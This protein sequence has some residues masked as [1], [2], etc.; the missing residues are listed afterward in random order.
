MVQGSW[1]SGEAKK[2]AKLIK[3]T[4]QEL[5][6]GFYEIFRLLDRNTIP[7]IQQEQFLLALRE[8]L[9][10]DDWQTE[11]RVIEKLQNLLNRSKAELLN[12]KNHKALMFPS[13]LQELA[14]LRGIAN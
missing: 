2:L 12:H 9:S 1:E 3:Q 5:E 11:A 4:E 8:K 13:A 14:A 10:C 6:S 7:Q